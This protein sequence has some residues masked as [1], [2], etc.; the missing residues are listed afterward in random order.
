[1][2]PERSCWLSK[3]I[4]SMEQVIKQ[5]PHLVAVYRRFVLETACRDGAKQGQG[6]RENE[7][8]GV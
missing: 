5:A 7:G 1:M 6:R 3:G 2:A 4:L 8:S